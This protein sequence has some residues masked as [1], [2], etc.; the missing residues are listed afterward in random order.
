MSAGA[1]DQPANRDQLDALQSIF[2]MSAY[3]H[4][5][6]HSRKCRRCGAWLAVDRPDPSLCSPCQARNGSRP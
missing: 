5:M 2:R 4:R 6:R 1:K 3:F